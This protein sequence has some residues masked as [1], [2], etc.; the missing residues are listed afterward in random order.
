MKTFSA[1][2]IF[3]TQRGRSL[4]LLLALLAGAPALT[5][6][7][8]A[9]IGVATVATVTAIDIAKDRRTVGTVVDDNLVELSI[10]KEVLTHADLGKQVHISPTSLNGVVLL[11]GEVATEQQKLL[12]EQIANSFQGVSQV[13]N[14]LDLVGNS[15]LT[16]RANDSLITGKVKTALLREKTVDASNVKVVTERGTVYLM[17]IVGPVEG[18]TA[19][20]IAQGISGVT[21]I[22]KIFM[23]PE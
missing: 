9:A 3:S 20:Q 10:K 2:N 12:A 4:G 17:G 18:E 19:V 13:V 22:I 16:S 11:T 21:R 23:S 14:Q 15:S 7:V 5:G 8:P 6:C 1:T